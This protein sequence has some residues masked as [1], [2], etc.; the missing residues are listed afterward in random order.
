MGLVLN[1]KTAPIF[2][3]VSERNRGRQYD[4]LHTAYNVSQSVDGF[5]IDR[6]FLCDLNFYAVQYLSVQPGRYRQAYNVSVGQH[7]APPWEEVEGKMEQVFDN[8]GRLWGRMGPIETA[9]YALWAV[10][11]IHPFAEGNGRS[12]RAFSYFILCYRLGAWLPGNRTIMELIRNGNRPEYCQILRRMDGTSGPNL[13]PD[14]VEMTAFLDR[15][16]LEQVGS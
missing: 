3:F 6:Q 11:H 14:L 9:A 10:N 4:F 5:T 13:L 15:L 8:L 16:L 7:L 2:Q 1:D 12:S